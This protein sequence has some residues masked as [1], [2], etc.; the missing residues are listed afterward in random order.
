MALADMKP[1]ELQPDWT[2]PAFDAERAPKRMEDGAAALD[3]LRDMVLRF[4]PPEQW[5][6][7]A[8]RRLM[9]DLSGTQRAIAGK[10]LASGM[11]AALWSTATA[12]YYAHKAN[13]VSR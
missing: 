9:D 12:A 7:L 10:L 8:L 13:L 11:T 2:V 4:N 6:R 3:R 1:A 5:D